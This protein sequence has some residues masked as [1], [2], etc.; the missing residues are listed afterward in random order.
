MS[1]WPCQS[2]MMRAAAVPVTRQGRGA[3]RGAETGVRGGRGACRCLPWPRG[4]CSGCGRSDERIPAWVVAPHGATP[5]SPSLCSARHCASDAP[6]AHRPTCVRRA[7]PPVPGAASR[8]CARRGARGLYSYVS[9][10]CPK[11]SS[12]PL[13]KAQEGVVR[14]EASLWTVPC[15]AACAL[16]Q[17]CD[18]SVL[19]L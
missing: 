16:P 13:L 9:Q 3:A 14:R 15:E 6:L 12:R 4:A 19:L 10:P 1:R 7:T 11:Q 18:L 5:T 2:R 17:R 8:R